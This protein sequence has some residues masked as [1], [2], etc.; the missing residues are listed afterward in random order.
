MWLKKLYDRVI[1]QHEDSVSFIILVFFLG[2]FIIARTIIHLY[3]ANILPDFYL[4][5][6]QTHVHHLNL[7][8]FLLSIT[9]YLSIARKTS[10]K[11]IMWLAALFG[12]GLGLTFDEFSLWFHLSDTYYSILSYEA[13]VVITALLINIIYFADLW[14]R[15]F[16]FLFRR[17]KGDDQNL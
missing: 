11:H 13:I 12:I 8:I 3:D 5:I 16:S 4:I 1:T 14:K 10:D 17:D 6:G 2:T 9:G 15:I 7:G